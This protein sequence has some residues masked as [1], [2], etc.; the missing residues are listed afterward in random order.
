MPN[1]KRFISW[2]LIF[3]PFI[4]FALLVLS[5]IIFHTV[6][7]FL[8]SR[9]LDNSLIFHP[10]Q[11]PECEDKKVFF[12]TSPIKDGLYR[13]IVPLGKFGPESGHV[14]PTKHTYFI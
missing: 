12:T 10:E 7:R 8:W 9:E 3:A 13:N 6:D 5:R 4:I 11:L 14:F 1:L 2:K